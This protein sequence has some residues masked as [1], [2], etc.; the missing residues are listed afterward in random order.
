MRL[1]ALSALMLCHGLLVACENKQP[2]STM[3]SQVQP[4]ELKR[5]L[6]S[7]RSEN[8][9]PALVLTEFSCDTHEIAYAGVLRVGSN[10]E[11]SPA[12]R[13]NIGSNAK[14]MLATVAG[15]LHEKGRLDLDA[16]LKDL[17]PEASARAP[18]KSEI[19]LAQL[20][21]HSSGLPAFDTGVA[22]E[23]VPD[24]TSS[25][26]SVTT[27][28][29]LWFL[30]QPT[31]STSG[32]KAV[33]SNAG[34][35]VAGAILEYVVGQPFDE[36]IQ[37]ELF[38]PLKLQAAFGEPRK[39]GTSEPFGHYVYD[40]SIVAYDSLD[41]PLPPFLIAAGN[42]SIS[43]EDYVTYLQIHLC[44]LQDQASSILGF[45]MVKRL[46]KPHIEGGAALGWGVT[47]L[48]GE[49]VSFHIGSTGEFTAYVAISPQKNRGLAALT[50]IGGTPSEAI[51]SW[52][53]ETVSQP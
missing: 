45:E 20:L 43:M 14:S 24:F 51:Q 41:P 49:K 19:T 23:T 1:F 52:L 25:S 32:E 7:L 8:E 34:Y 33:Y 17:W 44:G 39:L 2:I 5:E 30:E 15:R 29:A 31:V 4:T 22:L 16:P 46:H 42:V 9:I 37:A 18:D 40:E 26:M 47:E 10:Q 48:G 27:D 38:E 28:A 12:A 36:I 50:N 21:S 53:V 13:F 11:I 3:S 35:V 6:N